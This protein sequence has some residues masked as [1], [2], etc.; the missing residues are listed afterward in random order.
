MEYDFDKIINR[1]GTGSLKWDYVEKFM[2]DE[3]KIALDE[4]YIFGEGGK[5]FERINIACPRAVLEDGLKRI[6]RAVRTCC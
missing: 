3:G 1:R 4:G 6:E 5:G 2:Q